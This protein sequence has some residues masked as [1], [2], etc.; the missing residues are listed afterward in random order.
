MA[1][2][3]KGAQQPKV[4]VIGAGSL[5][6]GRQAVWQMVNS[7]HLNTGTLGLVDTDPVHL[8]RMSELAEKVIVHTGVKL[9]LEASTDAREILP[10]ADFVVFSFA[11]RSAWFRGIDCNVSGKYGV[12]MCSGDTIGPG[13]IFRTLREFPRILKY[14]RDVEEICPDAWVINYINPTTSNG[15]GIAKYAPSL[16]SFALCDGPHMPHFK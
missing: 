9:K 7:E 2:K 12:R 8:K 16:K 14:C 5:F 10:G 13:G 4:V 6:F 1:G 11:D 15:I 3:K